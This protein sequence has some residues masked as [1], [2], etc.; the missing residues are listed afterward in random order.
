MIPD[1]Y[2]RVSG[3]ILVVLAVAAAGAYV[4][5][6]LCDSV[7]IKPLRSNLR[8]ISF[9]FGLFLVPGWAHFRELQEL[10]KEEGLTVREQREVD[11]LTRK[12]KV[13]ILWRVAFFLLCAVV[14][15]VSAL[16]PDTPEFNSVFIPVASS[17]FFMSIYFVMTLFLNIWEVSSF[18]EKLARREASEAASRRLL[19]QFKEHKK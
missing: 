10:M 2:R 8:F 18:K 12:G 1:P 11:N 4:A 16:L 9:L 3:Q 15:G 13:R 6:W 17:M 14:T 7:G 19:T 5:F